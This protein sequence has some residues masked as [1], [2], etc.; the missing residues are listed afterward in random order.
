MSF[1]DIQQNAVN[2]MTN[3]NLYRITFLACLFRNK[4]EDFCCYISA[5]TYLFEMRQVKTYDRRSLC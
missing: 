3:H 2:A 1:K 4:R 5:H